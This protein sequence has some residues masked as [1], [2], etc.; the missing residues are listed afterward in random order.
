MY[1]VIKP[2]I[3][4]G[5]YRNGLFFLL[6][7][8]FYS[9]D[10]SAQQFNT[11][12]IY[13]PQA[14][15]TAHIWFRRAYISSGRPQQATITVATT[16]YYKLYINECNVGTA[17][18]Y[19]LRED[20]D[21][22]PISI[23]VDATP[24]LRPDTNVVALLYTPTTP[25]ISQRQIAVN[26]YGINNEGNKFSYSA[27]ASWLCRHANSQMTIDGGEYI[28]GREHDPSWKAATIYNQALWLNAETYSSREKELVKDYYNGYEDVKIKRI[29]TM[30]NLHLTQN[31]IILNPANSF[32]GFPRITLREAKRGERIQTSN[33]TYICN[34]DMDEQAYPIFN[35]GSWSTISINGDSRFRPSHVTTIE[36]IETE[37]SRLENY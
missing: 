24:Y 4:L 18:Y 20:N 14:D 30:S 33:F 29:T 1:Q 15:S 27:D 10:I 32:W 8:L 34:G 12:W 21:S 19:P 31:P 9:L 17:L 5:H 13:A 11:H 26:I 23:T 25:S 37:N 36:V 22:T 2:I 28:D 16:G 3:R 7:L 35:T 6:L